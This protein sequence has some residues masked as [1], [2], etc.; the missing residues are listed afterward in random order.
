MFVYA[1]LH[2][3]EG[4]FRGPLTGGARCPKV[5]F[6]ELVKISDVAKRLPSLQLFIDGVGE[7]LRTGLLG[8]FFGLQVGCGKLARTRETQLALAVP[9]SNALLRL[10]ILQSDAAA[11]IDEADLVLFS[12]LLNEVTNLESWLFWLSLNFF[13]LRD[14]QLVRWRRF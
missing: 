12:V 8:R 7:A 6:G 1:S 11:G 2:G 5:L 9:P 4:V 10:P 3:V 14:L 13:L